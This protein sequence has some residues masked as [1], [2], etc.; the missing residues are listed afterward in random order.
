[1]SVNR[2]RVTTHPSMYWHVLVG[3]VVNTPVQSLDPWG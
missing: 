3:L 1:M 2:Q